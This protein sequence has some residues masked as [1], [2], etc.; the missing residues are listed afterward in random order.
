M[1]S[2]FQRYPAEAQVYC[3][4]VQRLDF[5][6]YD[7]GRLRMVI[8]RARLTSSVTQESEHLMF[9]VLHLGDHNLQGGVREYS[10]EEEYQRLIL[11][12]KQA[13]SRADIPE[14][15]RAFD[16]GFGAGTY[17]LKS[18]FRD[19][20]RNTLNRILRSTLD[21]AETAY[22]Q[23]YEDHAPLMRFLAD[24]K[25]PLPKA[26]RTTAE[27]A[28]NSH[29]R[30]AL[31]EDKLEPARIQSLLEEAKDGGV[32]LDATTLEFTLRGTVERL[33][34]RVRT[35][36]TNL[37]AIYALREAVEVGATL[38]FPLTLWTAQNVCYG[39]LR[40]TQPTMTERVAAGDEDAA[41]WLR[42]VGDLAQQLSF[43]MTP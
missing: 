7:T 19:E 39:L 20:Q 33:A 41:L 25:T 23:L 10:S 42:N 24:L 16:R 22:R 2:V 3:Y 13:F 27:F 40:D 31:A 28:L 30:R 32:D 29:L 26:F 12:A 5:R 9:G 11:D 43:R 1:S 21:E 6:Q 8:G 36:P 18:M 35:V 14:I 15:I 34:E 17:S 38:P 37:E 4:H